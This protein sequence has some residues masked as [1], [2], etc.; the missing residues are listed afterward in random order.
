MNLIKKYFPNL[1]LQQIDQFAKLKELYYSW[2]KKINVISRKDIENL[3]QHHIL[4][5]LAIAKIINFAHDTN[6]LDVGTGGGLP[7]IPLAILFPKCN[8]CLIDA[9]EKKINV[10]SNITKS[11]ELKNVICKKQRV[12][13]VK[14]KYDFVISR[15]VTKFDKF[16]HLSNKCIHDKN[17]NSIKNGIL[18]LKGGDF[19]EEIMP[20]SEKINIYNISDF[21]VEPFFETKKIIH[22]KK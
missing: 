20:M 7:G 2:N 22:C 5:S 9:I 12:E 17:K 8:F 18:Y 4:H 6:L 13:N 19:E 15:A 1:T 16:Y 3:Y 21:F 14:E 10:A 11:V